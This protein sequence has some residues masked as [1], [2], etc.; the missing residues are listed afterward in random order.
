MVRT[1]LSQSDTNTNN[2]SNN[3][4]VTTTM[5]DSVNAA[6]LNGKGMKPS[7]N[8]TTNNV[9]TKNH[10][11]SSSSSHTNGNQNHKEVRFQMSTTNLSKI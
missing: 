8:G 2:S 7:F 4:N 5:K 6:A 10:P 1:N 11:P 9:S 3:N